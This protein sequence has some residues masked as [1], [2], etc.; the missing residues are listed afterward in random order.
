MFKYIDHLKKTYKYQIVKNKC[1]ITIN[2]KHI[3]DEYVKMFYMNATP[4]AARILASHYQA[5]NNCK[6]R[7]EYILNSNNVRLSSSKSNYLV[8]NFYSTDTFI[9]PKCD[10]SDSTCMLLPCR[11][12]LA[13]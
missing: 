8:E 11:H 9:L 6:Y 2:H 3:V 12:I 13:K 7:V 5:I 1:K 10:C 4:F